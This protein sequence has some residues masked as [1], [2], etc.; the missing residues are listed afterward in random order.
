MTRI[1]PVVDLKK[2]VVVRAENIK[3][4]LV[5]KPDPLLVIKAF[6]E[7]LECS[8]FYIE[9]LDATHQKGNNY[10]IIS[11][12]TRQKN[13][14][15][16]VNNGAN[17]AELTQKTSELGNVKVVIGS[18]TLKTMEDISAIIRAVDP[19]RL[20][21]SIE[22]RDYQ[23]ISG[24]AEI[25]KLGS[26]IELMDYL[27][28]FGPK[29]FIVLERTLIG[30]EAGII[31][32]DFVKNIM[33]RYTQKGIEIITGGGIRNIQDVLILKQM[34]IAG[35]LIGTALYRGIITKDDFKKLY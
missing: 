19:D 16:M 30:T 32:I 28:T 17:T 12:I 21:F 25:S 20:I 4:P 24:S 29:D 34:G 10:G 6:Q 26:A 35:V 31:N 23:V 22:M 33:S 3:G 8:E 27:I 18:S 14:S 9:D 1:I 5:D 7:K 15:L 11:K 13:I 2:G